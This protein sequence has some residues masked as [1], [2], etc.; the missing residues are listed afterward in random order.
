MNETSRSAV[1]KRPAFFHVCVQGIFGKFKMNYTRY[2]Q[3]HTRSLSM[4]YRDVIYTHFTHNLPR[5][6]ILYFDLHTNIRITH[7]IEE[8]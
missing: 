3:I 1:A 4:T 2:T 5:R 7:K 6:R 8:A